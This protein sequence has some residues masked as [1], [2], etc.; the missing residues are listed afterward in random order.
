MPDMN[1][2]LSFVAAHVIGQIFSNQSPVHPHVQI[3]LIQ[4]NENPLSDCSCDFFPD[5]VVEDSVEN[6]Y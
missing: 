5:V 6:V 2:Q 3:R 1:L 4:R